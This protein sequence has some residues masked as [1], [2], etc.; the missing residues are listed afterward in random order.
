MMLETPRCGVMWP[1]D[2]REAYKFHPV[3]PSRL[4]VTECLID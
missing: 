1:R 3:H 2:V 4:K